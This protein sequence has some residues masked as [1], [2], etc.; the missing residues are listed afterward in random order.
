MT[1]QIAVAGKGGTGKTSFCALLI[2]YLI[3]RGKT[4]ILAVDADANANLNEALGFS[5]ENETVSELIAATKDPNAIPSGMTQDVFIEYKLN[6]ALEEG[7]NVDLIVMGGP[8]GP[9]CFCF[10]NN[11]LRKYLDHLSKGYQYIV[12]DN[13]A[14]L[15]HISRRTTRDIDVMFVV[16]D[17]SARSVRS[18]GRIHQLVKQ[19]DTKVKNLYLIL[20]KAAPEDAEALKEEIEKTGLKLAGLIPA[21][22]MITSFDIGGK[23]LFDL[24]ENS[25]AVGELFKILDQLKI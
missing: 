1:V 24:P 17:C 12:M 18:A 5:I 13:E 11:I 7:K 6:A 22:P 9:G 3:E 23:A 2:R 4:P 15:E 20:N 25:P 19:L 8:E 16:S 14:G 10:P 21:D